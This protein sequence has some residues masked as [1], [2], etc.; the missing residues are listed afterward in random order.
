MKPATLAELQNAL[1]HMVTAVA[2]AKLYSLDHPQIKRLCEAARRCLDSLLKGHSMLSLLIVEGEILFDDFPLPPGLHSQKFARLMEQH[3]INRIIISQGVENDELGELIAFLVGAEKAYPA[4]S[5]LRFETL[6]N[7]DNLQPIKPLQASLPDDVDALQAIK[8]DSHG[9]LAEIFQGFSRQ[10]TIK[11]TGLAEIVSGFINAFHRET[12]SLLALM[13][14]R[15]MD[16]YTFTHGLN[17]CLLNL[18]QAIHLGIQGVLLH[19]IGIAALL[20]DIGK[21]HI[22]IEILNKPGKLDEKEWAIMKQHPIKGAR[23][24]L[25][26]PGVPQ[27]AVV[28]AFEHHLRYDLSGYPAV[29]R[30]WR[31]HLCSQM[32]TIADIY[33]AL[34]TKTPLSVA[35]TCR[36]MYRYSTK[37]GRPRVA[38]PI[39]SKLPVPART[40][41]RRSLN[42]K[43]PQLRMLKCLFTYQ[44]PSGRSRRNQP[45]TTAATACLQAPIQQDKDAR[46]KT[47]A[48]DSMLKS[49]FQPA[50]VPTIRY[51][52]MPPPAG[53]TILSPK[54]S[55]QVAIGP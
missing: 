6:A 30:Q 44:L 50:D 25:D 35:K 28:T 1:R 3:R 45:V 34:R 16:E 22:P 55:P 49:E 7:H 26:C 10:K 39:G 54:P 4:C 41:Y 43:Y 2:N 31:Q 19:D 14:L 27:L 53:I 42:G 18:A 52:R 32:T 15:S 13:P 38:P 51:L 46:T 5:H 48:A 9:R 17:V 40:G 36:G 29:S 47:P 20:H 37:I 24:L 33:D 11:M 21:L 8:I 23:R 12:P